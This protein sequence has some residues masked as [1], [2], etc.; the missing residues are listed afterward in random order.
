MQRSAE[1]GVSGGCHKSEQVACFCKIIRGHWSIENNLHFLLKYRCRPV[2][3]R[4]TYSKFKAV[5]IESVVGLAPP[6][7]WC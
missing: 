2:F 4:F 6:A 7:K 3:R 1:F 5:V